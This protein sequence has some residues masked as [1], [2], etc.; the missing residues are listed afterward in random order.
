MLHISPFQVKRVEGMVT[1]VPVEASVDSP[2]ESG[3]GA[4]NLEELSLFNLP[5]LQGDVL[6]HFINTL[7]HLH[8]LE[9][10]ACQYLRK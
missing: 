4:R 7:H 5:N 9:L 10:H 2:Q 3:L 8:T 6:S 1:R